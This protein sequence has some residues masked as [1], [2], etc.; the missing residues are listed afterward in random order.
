MRRVWR[1]DRRTVGT[2]RA[3][4][5]PPTD[6]GHSGAV[7]PVLEWVDRAA[8]AAATAWSGMY[9]VTAHVGNVHFRHPV[10]VGQ[11]VEVTGTVL[12]TGRTSMYINTVVRSGDAYT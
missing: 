6:Q 2:I 5:P 11:M 4:P 9:C 7:G 3:Q 10:T 8:F 1:A 12:Y